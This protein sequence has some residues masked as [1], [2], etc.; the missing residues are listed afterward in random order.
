MS[1]RYL[2]W[3]IYPFDTKHLPLLLV[4]TVARNSGRHVNVTIFFYVKPLRCKRKKRENQLINELKKKC[5]EFHWFII[6]KLTKAGSVFLTMINLRLALCQNASYT[7]YPQPVF[8][9]I[10]STKKQLLTV[11]TK[12]KRIYF[13]PQN[14]IHQ[15]C[16][17]FRMIILNDRFVYL[18]ETLKNYTT[19]NLK[20]DHQ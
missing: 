11:N 9:Q 14:E 15:F 4:C 1:G 10:Q 12:Q 7:R 20:S 13:F 3:I 18:T 17:N 5:V 16:Q 8:P 19:C 6:I 2:L